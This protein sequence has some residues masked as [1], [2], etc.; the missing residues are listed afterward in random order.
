[1]LYRFESFRDFLAHGITVLK[2]RENAKKIIT[3]S[4]SVSWHMQYE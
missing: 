2:L 3:E 1:M 4:L